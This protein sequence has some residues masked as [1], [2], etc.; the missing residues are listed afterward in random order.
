MKKKRGFLKVEDLEGDFITMVEQLVKIYKKIG[1]GKF[2]RPGLIRMLVMKDYLQVLE[3]F[4]N[5][6]NEIIKK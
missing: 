3:D 4:P 2:S 6:S 1:R 5:E